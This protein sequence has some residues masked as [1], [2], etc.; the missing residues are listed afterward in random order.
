LG[1]TGIGRALAPAVND[2]QVAPTGALFQAAA[3][4]PGNRV[5]GLPGRLQASRCDW[6]ALD[7]GARGERATGTAQRGIATFR[8]FAAFAGRQ[9]VVEPLAH[10][11]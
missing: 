5:T 7:S 11:P 10:R 9:Q 8:V 1:E 6:M 4:V 3:D 2:I